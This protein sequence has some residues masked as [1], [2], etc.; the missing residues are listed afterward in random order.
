MTVQNA[1]RSKNQADLYPYRSFVAAQTRLSPCLGH[2]LGFLSNESSTRYSCRI[3]CLEFS[4]VSG[5]PTNKSLNMDDLASLLHCESNRNNDIQ[6]RIVIVEDLTRDIVEL[7]GSTLNIDPF[8]FANHIDVFQPDIAT[9]R[10][11]MARLPSKAS[12]KDSLVLHYHRVLQFNSPTSERIL[13]Q[14]MN[15]PRKVK[16]LPNAKGARIGLARHCCSVLKTVGKDGLWIGTCLHTIQ[17]R[18]TYTKTGLVLVDPSTSM[19]CVSKHQADKA[20]MPVVL[21]SQPFQGGFEDFL[22]QPAFTG[23]ANSGPRLERHSLL[24]DLLFY[25]RNGQPQGLDLNGPTLIS[26]SQYPLRI[27]AAEW[28]VYLELMYHSTKQYEFTPGTIPTALEQISTLYADLSNLQKWG[29]RGMATSYKLRY[30]I[31]FLEVDPDHD[32]DE[33]LKTL[34]LKDFN[35]IAS[36]VDVYSCRLSEMVPIV[37]SLIQI[38][39]SRRSLMETANISRLTHLAMVFVPLTFVTG[40]FSMDESIAPGGKAFWLYFAVAI[41]ICLIV[42][43]LARPPIGSLKSLAMAVSNSRRTLPLR[44]Q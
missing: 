1:I 4:T 36:R 37:T 21:Q 16:L 40:L 44:G 24:E 41:P 27:I 33:E 25:W 34:L 9:P 13:V 28:M 7:L 5:A 43:C 39:D 20:A 30:V 35:Y 31:D 2:L 26:L 23:F 32:Q 3:A 8:F 19:F 22:S 12:A 10:P 42:Y 11:Y 14:A 17:W 38:I 29:R 15:V 18:Y 6:G